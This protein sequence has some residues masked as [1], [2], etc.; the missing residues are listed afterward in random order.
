MK[1]YVTTDSSQHVIAYHTKDTFSPMVEVVQDEPFIDVTKLAGYKVER[2][3]DGLD[4]LVFDEEKWAEIVA[5]QKKEQAIADGAVMM[6]KV[7]KA[8]ILANATDAE[9]YVMRYMYPTWDGNGVQYEKNDRFIYNDKFYRALQDHTSQP[10]WTPDTASSLYVE[11]SDP[12][13]EYPEWRRPTMAE[14]AYNT[15]DKVTYNGK[16]YTS[17]IDANTWSPDEYSAGWE[18]VIE[19]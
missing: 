17:K 3:D 16:K 5:A 19:E 8:N 14:N 15:G 4:H 18:E 9:A 6:D 10:D 11:I 13:V 1:V 2:K 7:I 12:N